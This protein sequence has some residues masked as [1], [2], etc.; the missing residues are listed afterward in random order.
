MVSA[1][2]ISDELAT[3]AEYLELDGQEGRAHAYDKAARSLQGMHYIPPNPASINGVG[4]SIRTVIA[5]LQRTGHIDELET[6]K[7]EYS[8]YETLKEID[9]VGTAR[10]KQMHEKFHIEDLDDLFLVGDDL[11]MLPRVG[12]KRAESILDSA[13]E[14]KNE[15]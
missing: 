7:E 3:F 4:E 8:W 6:L 1:D 14:V 10:A 9:G 12:N 2:Y 15:R 13:R 5:R 11:T